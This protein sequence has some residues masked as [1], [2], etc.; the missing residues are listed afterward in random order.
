MVG[1]RTV[2]VVSP[3]DANEI[4]LAADAQG[5]QASTA[6][7]RDIA[8]AKPQ[9]DPVETAA[10]QRTV[11]EV[12]SASWIAQVLAALGGAVAAG[13]ARL[14]PDRL[15]AAADVWVSDCHSGAE[16]TG[17]ARSGRPDDRLR[18]EPGMTSITP[19]P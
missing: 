8:E 4:D 14:V 5:T 12:G 15:R 17:P 3:D 16:P 6:A 9:P 7:P 1:G 19:S 2:Q 10:A 13:S 18:E 11:S